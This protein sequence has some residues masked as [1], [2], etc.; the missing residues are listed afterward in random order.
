VV[1]LHAFWDELVVVVF[2]EDAVDDPFGVAGSFAGVGVA[3]LGLCSLPEPALVVVDDD[4]P[5]EAGE[6]CSVEDVRW[7]WHAR[8]L[9]SLTYPR[10]VCK[11]AVERRLMSEPTTESN[12][13]QWVSEFPHQ[14]RLIRS[15]GW[16]NIFGAMQPPN[17][18]APEEW[19][20]LIESL[21]GESA[22]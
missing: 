10:I 12:L 13:S 6:F 17:E 14:A 16:R 3:V 11:I 1:E 19:T 9:A 4:L 5:V 15:P 2:P 20:R 22:T 21:N 7:V 18:E 8:M